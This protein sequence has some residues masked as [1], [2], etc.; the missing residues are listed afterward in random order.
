MRSSAISGDL[1]SGVHPWCACVCYAYS[2]VT[3]IVASSS[4]SFSIVTPPPPPPRLLPSSL[5]AR[6]RVRHAAHSSRLWSSLRNYTRRERADEGV[7]G[8]ERGGPASSTPCQIN[9]FR[10]RVASRGAETVGVGRAP[11]TRRT[12]TGCPRA[13]PRSAPRGRAPARGAGRDP[14]RR[15]R[16]SRCRCRR[17]RLHPRP[18]GPRGAPGSA[19][20][21]APCS[22]PPPMPR[23]ARTAVAAWEHKLIRLSAPKKEP[24]RFLLLR[25]QR[26]NFEEAADPTIALRPH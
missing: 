22:Q 9:T 5:L 26:L 10:L 12:P 11:Y 2:P 23:S 6:R 17:P 24:S 20:R 18:A 14:P 8:G 21:A 13:P 7:K 3:V 19:G 1:R 15:L 16:T 25:S 4:T